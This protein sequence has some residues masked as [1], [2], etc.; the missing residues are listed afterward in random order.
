MSGFFRYGFIFLILIILFPVNVSASRLYDAEAV[1]TLRDGLPCFSYPQDEEIRKLPYS[2][3]YLSVSKPGPIGGVM[4]E[5]QTSNWEK[6]L[7]PNSPK[8]CI[9]YGGPHR[10]IK[11]YYDPAKPLFMD[12]PY[13][14]F[15]RVGTLEGPLYE[16][17]FL[18][19]FCLVRDEKG[20]TVI[21]DIKRDSKTDEWVCLKPGEKPPRSFWQRLFGK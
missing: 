17:K 12:T 1:I 21:V 4:W 18:S 2:F 8:T 16:R 20:N 9:R 19:S 5:I 11:N 15:I 14:V 3:G 6:L 7:E 10:G 13:L